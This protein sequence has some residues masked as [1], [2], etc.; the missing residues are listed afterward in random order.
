MKV[1]NIVPGFGG[2]FYCGNCLRDS[3][4]VKSLRAAGH[5]AITLP[6]Y[7]PLSSTDFEHE[8]EVPVFYG[9]VNVYLEQKFSL[10]RGSPKWLHSLLNSNFILRY[11]AK[12]SGST[13]ATGLEAMTISMLQGSEGR[14][15]AELEELIHFLKHHEKPD[16]VHLSNALLLG[17][18][19]RIR[20]ELK[21]PV[22]CSL[23]DEDVWVDAMDEPYRSQVWA[24]MGQKAA[25]VDALIAVSDYFAQKVKTKMNIPVEKLF[26]VHI[27]VDP[28]KYSVKVPNLIEP[29]IG[30]LSRMN[31]ENGF[32]ILIDAFIMLK[33]N[34][35]YSRARLK[36]TGGKTA[37]DEK[38][39]GLQMNKLKGMGFGNDIE[40]V[41]DFRT[42]M[43]GAFFDG[44]TLLSVPV[45]DGE[46]FGLYQLESLASGI[47]LVQPNVGAFP[48]II[49]ATGGGVTYSPNT[50]EALAAKW[51]EVLSNPEGIAR[52]SRHGRDAIENKYNTSVLID[53]MVEVYSYAIENFKA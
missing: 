4:Y 17:L 27:G 41:E 11:A 37:D 10:F 16:V 36:V 33:R 38:F 47:P 49:Q 12:K 1:V 35:T 14:Q 28:A 8:R 25:N 22:V 3:A 15:A 43:L 45:I 30:Y 39:I 32:G 6:M 42:E 52:M 5:E 48:E 40:F 34:P 2:T 7:M 24:L 53:R 29:T 50:P 31:H 20:E 18:A 9:A 26:V 44:L 46:A 19:N 23:Q 13:R 51:A 21:I